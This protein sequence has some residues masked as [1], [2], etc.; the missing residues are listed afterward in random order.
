[1]NYQKLFNYLSREHG[2]DLLES[3]LQEV[4]RIVNE[5]QWIEFTQEKPIESGFYFLKGK[6]DA[7]ACIYY[8]TE[9]LQWELGDLAHN[10]FTDDYIYWLKEL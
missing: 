8:Y 3:E 10:Y 9:T 2:V 4:C 1:M 7:K 6:K 5:S